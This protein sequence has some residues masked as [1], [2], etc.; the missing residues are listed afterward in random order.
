MKPS[1]STPLLQPSK[2]IFS[3]ALVL[4]LVPWFLFTTT[5]A[6]Y[7]YLYHYDR[8]LGIF[9]CAA[10]VT[11]QL[12]LC[13]LLGTNRSA[14]VRKVGY[15]AAVFVVAGVLAGLANEYQNLAYYH[16]YNSMNQYSN[17]LPTVSVRT[18]LD[19][20][21]IYF[22]QSTMIDT[23]RSAAFKSYDSP[24][25][26][27]CVAPV[28]DDSFLPT[29]EVG[30]WAV[31]TDC[32]G[33]RAAFFCDDAEK[34]GV[35]TAIVLLP[36]E[37]VLPPWLAELGAGAN[38]YGDY[39]KALSLAEAAY[40]TTAAPEVRLVRWV[41]DVDGFINVYRQRGLGFASECMAAAFWVLVVMVLLMLASGRKV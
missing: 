35:K 27:F 12:F 8:N 22:S 39:L 20:G 13:A 34:P 10:S 36:P 19:A 33:Q 24:G 29:D 38:H 6:T 26:T 25:V 1:A 23:A 2:E 5:L 30:I 14:W 11:G 37:E 28:L 31:G 40:G 16:K 32:C 9:I 3:H 21:V 15:F 17:V 41:A 4:V 7:F 18:V